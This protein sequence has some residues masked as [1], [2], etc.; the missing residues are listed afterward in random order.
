M[1]M[2]MK[3]IVV[4]KNMGVGTYVRV[5]KHGLYLDSDSIL[6]VCSSRASSSLPLISLV[7]EY[8]GR[9]IGKVLPATL[10]AATR[11]TIYSSMSVYVRSDQIRGVP[12]MNVYTLITVTS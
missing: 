6:S 12:K 4:M 5:I 9:K 3:I 10:A 11:P 8:H 2:N 7:L 1:K